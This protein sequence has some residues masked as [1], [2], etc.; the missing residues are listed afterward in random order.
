MKPGSTYEDAGR[1]I[2]DRYVLVHTKDWASKFEMLMLMFRK[3]RQLRSGKI[4]VRC[5]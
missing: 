5:V 2:I 4:P 3:L 1:F